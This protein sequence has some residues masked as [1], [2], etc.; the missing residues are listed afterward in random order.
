MFILVARGGQSRI[1]EQ[2]FRFSF[3]L[4]RSF[5]SCSPVGTRARGLVGVRVHAR[6]IP[7][8]RAG[9]PEEDFFRR[10]RGRAFE[11]VGGVLRRFFVFL[12]LCAGPSR[13]FLEFNDPCSLPPSPLPNFFPGS[14][15][16]I[17]QRLRSIFTMIN[18]E[19]EYSFSLRS[20]ASSHA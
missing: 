12:R 15:R 4:A 20:G 7:D 16:I 9:V 2:P 13:G 14:A 1:E 5:I 8:K 17:C 19:R 11:V 10:K 3:H 18:D 6:E